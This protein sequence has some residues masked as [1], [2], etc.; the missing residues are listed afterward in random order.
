MEKEVISDTTCDGLQICTENFPHTMSTC[1][2]I[3]YGARGTGLLKCQGHKLIV[4]PQLQ[5]WVQP[6]QTSL[7]F[8]P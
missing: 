5:C 2:K 7:L 1:E 4:V 8:L 6:G 3:F